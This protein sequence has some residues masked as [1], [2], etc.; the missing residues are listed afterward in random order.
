M[1]ASSLSP[2]PPSLEKGESY[3]DLV[4]RQF[5]R[6]R[7][8][9]VSLLYVLLLFVIAIGAPFLASNRPIILIGSFNGVYQDRFEEWQLGGHPALLEA[10]RSDATV[11][12]QLRRFRLSVRQGAVERQLQ[13]MASQ[14]ASEPAEILLQYLAE[15]R[16]AVP[17]SLA[18]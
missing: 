16:K 7:L 4:F 10:L 9:V 5:R 15:Y 1:A 6:N 13:Y 14:L 17:M 2:V 3:W 8:A 11:S 18:G 12:D